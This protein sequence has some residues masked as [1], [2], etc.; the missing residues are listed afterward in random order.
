MTFL[1]WDFGADFEWT[2]FDE[3]LTPTSKAD[4]E[5]KGAK[6][7]DADKDGLSDEYEKITR[8]SAK[9]KTK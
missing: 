3:E 7:F 5:E 6:G 8:T 4:Q 9:T 1:F 2:P